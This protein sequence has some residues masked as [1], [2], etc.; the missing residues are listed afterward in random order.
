MCRDSPHFANDYVEII[1][2]FIFPK[3]E[4]MHIK[5]YADLYKYKV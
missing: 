5:S 3:K 4:A 1:D 2:S